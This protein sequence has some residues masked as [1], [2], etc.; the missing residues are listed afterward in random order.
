MSRAFT[1]L[2][3]LLWSFANLLGAA[4]TVKLAVP[5]FSED[6]IVNTTIGMRSFYKT[7]FHLKSEIH[8]RN[9][10]P[11]ILVH[12]YRYGEFG[13]TYAPGRAEVSCKNMHKAYQAIGKTPVP[14]DE[15]IAVLGATANGLMIASKLAKSGYS[16]TI[17]ADN[18]S[19][20]TFADIHARIFMPFANAKKIEGEFIEN[21]EILSYKIYEAWANP[22]NN[23][24]YRGVTPIDLYLINDEGSFNFLVKNGLI[25]EAK[26]VNIAFSDDKNISATK[27]K[28]F[29]LDTPLLM[30]EMM[31]KCKALGVKFVQR[32]IIDLSDSL[33]L[34][35]NVIFNCIGLGSNEIFTDNKVVPFVCHTISLQD[36]VGIDYVI[37]ANHSDETYT[38]WLANNKKMTISGTFL[39]FDQD[40]FSEAANI[41]R[42]FERAKQLVMN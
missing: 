3:L 32:R 26:A 38:Y 35:A 24:G 31:Q 11:V 22:K 10:K 36:T 5:N 13:W 9:G 1:S 14:A 19:P 21:L 39:D 8:Y 2:I 15:K 29:I 20:N 7:P 34:D 6:K 27:Y 40:G 23:S 37:Y 42:L 25:P 28:S 33:S 4:E 17:Y 30:K 12:N 41:K 18:F 16:V